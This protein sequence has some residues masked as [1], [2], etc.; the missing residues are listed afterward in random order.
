MNIIVISTEA[1]RFFIGSVME[2][3]SKFDS[4]ICY[5]DLSTS[6]CSGRDDDHF[7]RM[8]IAYSPKKVKTFSQT[9]NNSGGKVSLV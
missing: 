4:I 7:L 3:S 5:K 1:H 6:P 9:L 8:T 2:K